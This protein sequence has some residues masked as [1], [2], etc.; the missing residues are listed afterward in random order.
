MHILTSYSNHRVISR[1]AL[2]IMSVA[3]RL[4]TIP[5]L[6]CRIYTVAF[7]LRQRAQVFRCPLLP[8]SL[9]LSLQCPL[10]SPINLALAFTLHSLGCIPILLTRIPFLWS[11]V[12][13][14]INLPM[15]MPHLAKT[16]IRHPPWCNMEVFPLVDQK[17]VEFSVPCSADTEP[18]S[19]HPSS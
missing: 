7:E 15:P 3:T 19:F 6:Q 2:Y 5:L 11:Q 8:L 4:P 14:D 13:W 17:Y 12:I 1:K 10:P 9:V 16:E 18:S